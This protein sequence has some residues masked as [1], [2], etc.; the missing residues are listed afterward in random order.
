MPNIYKIVDTSSPDYFLVDGVP[1]NK[2]NAGAEFRYQVEKYFPGMFFLNEISKR[3]G[4][5]GMQESLFQCEFTPD[6][7]SDNSFYI[8]VLEI[9]SGGRSLPLEHRIQF[10]N[11]KL[12]IPSLDKFSVMTNFCEETINL[13]DKECYII[14]VTKQSLNDHNVI[15]SSFHP[16]NIINERASNIEKEA[17]TPKSIQVNV[18]SIQEAY[19]ENLSCQVKDDKFYIINYKPQYLLWYMANRDELHLADIQTVKDLITEAKTNY[20]FLEIPPSST[21]ED[22]SRIITALRTKPFLL[23]AG[24]SGTG[25]SQKVQELAYMTCPQRLAS[26]P[27]MPGNYCLI[28][29]KPNWHDSTELLGY[30]SSLTEKYELTDFVR[31]VYKATQNP[32]VPFFVCLDEMNLAPVEQYFAEYLSVLET[33]KLI[34]GKIVS[35]PLL[36]K[37]TF[38]D[39]KTTKRVEAYSDSAYNAE[40][41]TEPKSLYTPEDVEVI[42][43]LQE[44]GLR[45]PENLF[46]IGTVNMD[47]TTHQFSRKVIDRAF[48]IEMNG[49][50]LEDMFD[51]KEPLVYLDDPVKLSMFKPQ[52]VR[53]KE[54]LEAFS[55]YRDTI[56][57]NVPQLLNDINQIL[58]NT[59]FRVSYR[60]QNELILYIGNILLENNEVDDVAPIINEAFLNILLEKILP[61]VEGEEKLLKSP[62]GG[63]TTVFDDLLG[64]IEAMQSD[65]GA[66]NNVKAKLIEMRTKLKNSYFT[67]FFS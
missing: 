34:N 50:N 33:R 58:K 8:Y 12:W 55:Q 21:Y 19:K 16:S 25:K 53:A 44:N 13:E 65:E 3:V 24:I 5:S 22:K 9:E 37:E 42:K 20:H 27:T 7:T 51:E 56:V 63:S 15:F 61:R 14:G 62:N 40:V 54:V 59:P 30:Y 67:N 43:Y 31:F 6:E 60:V 48:T 64:Y 2:F 17:T 45:L 4:N 28:E 41:Q 46:V 39:L 29:V 11:N 36:T 57:T 1:F 23:L 18:Q 35:A 66:Y 32:D 49:G 52:F 10:R 47:D 26:D 38:K